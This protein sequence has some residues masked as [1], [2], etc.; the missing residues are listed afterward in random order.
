MN[1]FLDTNICI[2]FLKGKGEN[3]EKNIRKLNPNRI[4]IPSVV[5]AEL[6]LGVFKSNDQKKNREIVL[7]FLDPFEIIGFN[8]I[9]SE[10]YAEVRSGLEIQGIPI[11]PNDLLV[12]SVVLSSNGILVTNNEKE[13][14]RIPNLKIENWL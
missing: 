1:Y 3:I 2:Y 7:S 12:A 8:D 14:K 9:E 10:I 6:L 4:K 11:G 13:F 5:K